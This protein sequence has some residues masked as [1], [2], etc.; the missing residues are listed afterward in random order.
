MSPVSAADSPATRERVSSCARP[1]ASADGAVALTFADNARGDAIGRATVGAEAARA[2]TGTAAR[3]AGVTAGADKTGASAETL[4][5]LR[6]RLGTRDPPI[7]APERA[8]A[9]WAPATGVTGETRAL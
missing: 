1:E 4:R 8:A 7:G 9:D 3:A 6:E 2:A 5:E